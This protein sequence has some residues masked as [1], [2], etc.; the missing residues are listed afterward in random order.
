MSGIKK[1]DRNLEWITAYR[2]LE[3]PG[4]MKA[5][6]SSN[7]VF[8]GGA[9]VIGTTAIVYVMLMNRNTMLLNEIE[10]HKEYITDQRNIDKKEWNLLLQERSESLVNYR[11]GAEQYLEQLANTNRI[12]EETYRYYEEALVESAGPDAYIASFVTTH[13]TVEIIGVVAN[14]E[15]PRTYAE[16]LANLTDDEGNP[17][18][19]SVNYNG[20]SRV[21]ATGR[22]EFTINV[23]LWHKLK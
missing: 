5:K 19:A 10:E 11:E 18:F 21:S 9:L 15:M 7:M 13:N 16:Y 3:N 22:Y 12:S 17:K 1:R 2:D 14:E 20:F 6:Q 4:R 8:I 23:V